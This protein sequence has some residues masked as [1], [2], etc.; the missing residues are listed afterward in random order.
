MKYLYLVVAILVLALASCKSDQDGKSAMDRQNEKVA[1]EAVQAIK[2][3]LDQ[4]KAAAGQESARTK[5]MDEQAK[6]Q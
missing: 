5:T 1:G 3:P 2:T 4:A 6:S